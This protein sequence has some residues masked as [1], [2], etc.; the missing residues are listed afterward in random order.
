MF[1]SDADIVANPE[2]VTIEPF[3]PYQVREDAEGSRVLS[4]GLGPA[5]YDVR[6]KPHWKIFGGQGATMIA[7]N[8]IIDPKNFDEKRFLQEI[9]GDELVLHPK[10]YALAVTLE[11][12]KLSDDVQGTFFAKSTYARCGLLLNTTNVQPGFEGEVVMEFYNAAPF[13][14]LI[15]ANEGFAQIKFD[16][17]LSSADSSYAKSGTYQG[18]SGIQVPKI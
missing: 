1:L 15:R 11:R 16:L 8:G 17:A 14:I 13:P 6:L 4:Y 5:G 18:Q 7:W 10:Q 2:L 3:V 12:F 9:E